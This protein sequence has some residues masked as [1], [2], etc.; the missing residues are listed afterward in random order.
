MT[1]RPHLS[2]EQIG[3]LRAWADLDRF[4]LIEVP[5]SREEGW[6]EIGEIDVE[7]EFGSWPPRPRREPE[8]SGRTLITRV[9]FGCLAV[10]ELAELLDRVFSEDYRFVQTGLTR[11]GGARPGGKVTCRGSFQV[12]EAGQ[13]LAESFEYAPLI[14]FARH[15][16]H[17]RSTGSALDKAVGLALAAIGDREDLLRDQWETLSDA[18]LE[19]FDAVRRVVRSVRVQHD[20]SRFA[21]S[22][23]VPGEQPPGQ[24]PAFFRADLLRAATQPTPLV[25]D[26][27]RRRPGHRPP[28]AVDVS[29]RVGLEPL[30]DP[31]QLPRAAW[32][33][34]RRPRL[35]QQIAVT[36]I[37]SADRDRLLSVNGPP[38]TGKS[39]L[40][41]DVYANVVTAR[42]AVM[43]GFDDPR[44]GFG[45]VQPVTT[46]TGR[47]QA[48][49]Q[50]LSALVGFEML[51]AS[52]NNAAV[53][54]VS[55]EL[56]SAAEIKGHLAETL[57][58]FRD[59][60][61]PWPDRQS[62]SDD[63]DVRPGLLPVAR[64]WG[65]AAAALGSRS[66]VGAFMKVV[67]RYLPASADGTHLLKALR[68][69]PTSAEWA[70]VRRRFRE[71]Q[72]TI[73]DEV[74]RLT[75]LAA[76][77]RQDESMSSEPPCRRSEH[78]RMLRN[79][80]WQRRR[81]GQRPQV[82]R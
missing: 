56:P 24:L 68:S 18:G 42:A 77:L 53:E 51:L 6:A 16:E 59:A 22:W 57:G 7:K 23:V 14:D 15:V 39:T 58:Y 28:S 38:G 40:L 54:N 46:T 10:S 76:D 43:V 49:H 66:R 67:G 48:I 37:G 32:P 69:R 2:P 29:S 62:G 61:N 12:D 78:D 27:L 47:R 34:G 44:T 25:A 17:Y 55:T 9:F 21:T 45:P 31:R 19:G 26:L 11:S 60:A 80:S 71:A 64:A 72:Q 81:H 50:P 35:S 70:A 30:L 73:D 52:S 65:L 82:A 3:T 33:T 4:E 63:A 36:A 20:K 1:E 74:D 13:L 75:Q 5:D 41:R 79:E 8:K